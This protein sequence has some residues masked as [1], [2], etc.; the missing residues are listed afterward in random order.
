MTII[1][2]QACPKTNLF[3]GLDQRAERLL[4]SPGSI[5]LD[6]HHKN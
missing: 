3:P 6:Y 2:R 1:K 5:I 4:V